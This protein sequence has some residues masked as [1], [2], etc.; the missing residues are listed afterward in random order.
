MKN[1]MNDLFFTYI[2]LYGQAFAGEIA[3]VLQSAAAVCERTG[4]DLVCVANEMLNDLF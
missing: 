4:D 1:T 3:D 2:R